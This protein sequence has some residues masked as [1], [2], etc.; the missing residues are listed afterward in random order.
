M[1]LSHVDVSLSLSLSLPLSKSNEKMSSGKDKKRIIR[2]KSTDFQIQQCRQLHFT[3]LTPGGWSRAR[4][5]RGSEEVKGCPAG[6]QGTFFLSVSPEP[7]TVSGPG[8]HVVTG[9]CVFEVTSAPL[10]LPLT[11]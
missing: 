8:E 4:T 2:K 5:S 1:F 10:C 9:L 3:L 7:G 11:L 6:G